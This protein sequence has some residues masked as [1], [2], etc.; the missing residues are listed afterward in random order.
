MYEKLEQTVKMVETKE[1][2]PIFVLHIL[3]ITVF[4]GKLL[5]EIDPKFF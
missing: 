4:I 3:F 5:L 2:I 1:N